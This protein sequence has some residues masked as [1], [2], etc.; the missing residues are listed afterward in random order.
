MIFQAEGNDS[1]HGEDSSYRRYRFSSSGGSG[2]G[3]WNDSIPNNI[4]LV[5]GL[6]DDA[7]ENDVS[8]FLIAMIFIGF[9]FNGF[10]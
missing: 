2:K 8:G 7:D 9:W 10:L 5:R 6:P 3:R 4:V 1:S